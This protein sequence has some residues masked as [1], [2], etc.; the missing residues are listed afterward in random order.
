MYSLFLVSIFVS[1]LLLVFFQRFRSVFRLTTAP[2]VA[3]LCEYTDDDA[4]FESSTLKFRKQIAKQAA[5]ACA[6][7]VSADLEVCVNS[8]ETGDVVPL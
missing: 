3:N 5:D 8:G 4:V 6:A 1:I 7:A 2:P